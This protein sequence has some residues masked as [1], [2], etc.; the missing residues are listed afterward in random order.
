MAQ[1]YQ[2]LQ[3][4]TQAQRNASEALQAAN[5]ALA[6]A[7]D[8]EK[9]ALNAQSEAQI[10]VMQGKLLVEIARTTMLAAQLALVLCEQGQ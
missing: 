4:A 5:R 2:T 1:T 3:A 6:A 7:I 8:A 9:A 10:R